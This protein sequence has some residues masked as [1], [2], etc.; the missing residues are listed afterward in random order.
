[1]EVIAVLCTSMYRRVMSPHFF[2]LITKVHFQCTIKRTRQ[3]ET[4]F[5]YACIRLPHFQ[6][7]C[8][9]SLFG[10]FSL[11]RLPTSLVSGIFT[12]ASFIWMSLICSK[13][14]TRKVERKFRISFISAVVLR[15]LLVWCDASRVFGH[16]N[17]PMG[18]KTTL[19]PSL[20]TL[21][22]GG[23][24]LCWCLLQITGKRVKALATYYIHCTST[25][26]YFFAVV[27]K[28]RLCFGDVTNGSEW[29]LVWP[30]LR[31]G[32]KNVNEWMCIFSERKAW[33]LAA[34][35]IL[36]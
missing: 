16:F 34:E 26:I 12:E 17:F 33:A 28:L 1:M 30:Y 15:V 13:L 20:F 36:L 27:I 25:N 9:L 11:A 18:N 19:R 31:S 4:F 29:K 23:T 14:G 6:L 5:L 24:E 8:F 7:S 3:V 32:P 22:P 35:K 2:L 21:L 10:S